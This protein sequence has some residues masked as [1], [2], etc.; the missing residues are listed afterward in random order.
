MIRTLPVVSKEV[1][2][3]VSVILFVVVAELSVTA[4]KLPATALAFIFDNPPPSP[5][6]T[7]PDMRFISR[8]ATLLF[9]KASWSVDAPEPLYFCILRP[10]LQPAI[11]INTNDYFHG[12]MRHFP[13][14]KSVGSS[15]FCFGILKP[16]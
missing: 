8:V 15:D 16:P 2:P 12:K 10:V 9:S 1:T 3:F 6:Y 14:V 11:L 5:I 13:L 4:C 7:A